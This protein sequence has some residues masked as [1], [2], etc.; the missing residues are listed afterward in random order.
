MKIVRTRDEE[1]GKDYYMLTYLCK[2]AQDCWDKFSADDLFW[3]DS[4]RD[5][6]Y[7]VSE[8]I[9]REEKKEVKS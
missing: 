4:E 3:N 5:I 7:T 8:K 2:T 6:L 1:T 9:L